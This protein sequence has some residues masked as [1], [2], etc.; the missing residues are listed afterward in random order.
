MKLDIDTQLGTIR[1]ECDQEAHLRHAVGPVLGSVFEPGK[2]EREVLLGTVK[3]WFKGSHLHGKSR[4]R[5]A[6]KSKLLWQP[7]PRV[8][9]FKNLAWLV[10]RMFQTPRPLAAGVLQR[11]GF[12]TYQFL[13]TEFVQELVPFDEG[14]RAAS[15]DERS[16]SIDELARE[17]A[18]MHALH[19]AHRDVFTRNLR[20]G[21]RG[22][23]RRVWFMDCA[24]GGRARSLGDAAYD[25]GCLWLGAASLFDAGEEKRFFDVYFAE[26]TAQGA[27]IS[28]RKLLARAAKYRKKWI[29]RIAKDPAR[30]RPTEPPAPDWNW[31]RVVE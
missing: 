10:E 17:L 23:A 24:R 18:R 20:I 6:L 5:F 3:A 9:E 29:A 19:F 25:L 11:H 2:T 27:P 12:P 22:A 16:S 26:R 28:P 21:P 1:G 8:R 4:L 31:K 14:L 13:C 15:A 7:S 30:W